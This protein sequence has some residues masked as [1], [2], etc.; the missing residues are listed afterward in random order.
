MK[1]LIV[2]GVK[3]IT[4]KQDI[5][6]PEIGEYQVLTKTIACAL[7]NGTDLK[8]IDGHLRG[9]PNY[10]AVLGHESVGIVVKM[11][12]KV[13]SFKI[14][15]KVLRTTL[16]DTREYYCLWGGFGEYGFAEDYQARLED[17]VPADEGYSTQ[18]VV[19]QQVEG[20]DATMLITLKEITSALD[21]LMMKPGMN[22]AVIGCGPVGLSMVAVARLMGAGKIIL[23]G[24]HPE[25]MKTAQ[26]LGADRIFYSDK[27][28]TKE[29]IKT[30][31]PAGVDLFI[32][33]VGRTA[34]IDQGMQS[35]TETGKIALYGIGMH[36]GDAIDWDKAPYN[37]NIHSV[38]WPIPLAESRVHQRVM[39]YVT[40]GRLN[41]K[42]FVT[43][44]LP[45][46]EY[47]EGIRLVNSREGMK[48]ALYF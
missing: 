28:D 26:K 2:D 8:I 23:G 42:D 30:L 43:H 39:Q 44:K 38:Q 22:V 24:H 16:K 32:D 5:P 10:P 20:V 3:G 40:E 31:V 4:L 47:E 21:R 6:M 37:F 17:G 46:E 34:I 7:C 29:A 36:T 9:F 15:D 33:C 19:P 35:V 1:G 18:Q 45:I 41:L 14:G 25:R 11:G 48:V 12:N 13:R 27:E